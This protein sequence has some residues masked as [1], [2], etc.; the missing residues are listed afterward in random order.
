MNTVPN[1]DDYALLSPKIPRTTI[2]SPPGLLFDLMKLL[3]MN[4]ICLA[5]MKNTECLE[6]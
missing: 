3:L 2:F 5:M 4:M 6:T 1:I